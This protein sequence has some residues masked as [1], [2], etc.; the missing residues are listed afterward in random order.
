[1]SDC[2]SIDPLVTPYIDNELPQD[3]HARVDA[4]LRACPPCHSRVAAERAVRDLIRARAPLVCS[5]RAS[6]ALRAAVDF[7][8]RT[9]VG[10]PMGERSSAAIG[11][12]SRLPALA[13]AATLVL[14]V[15]GVFVY[16]GTI[17]SS[18]VLA[19]ELTAD[20]VKCFALNR[21]FGT[22]AEAAAVESAMRAG[23]DWPLHIKAGFAAVG[24]EL[25]GS[26]PCLSGE[27]R[28]A[29]IMCRHNGRP[30][31]IFM[32]PQRARAEEVVEVMGHQARIWSADGRTFV[33]IA[34][35]PRPEVQRMASA[36][37]AALR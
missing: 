32:L 23:F 19:V 10:G 33:M 12:R 34:N 35:E 11:K 31:S 17:H 21:L 3:E 15:G 20:H 13:L 30:V 16:E 2:R 28:V 24:L 22:H 1:M 14:A 27:G 7:A 9:T 26:R 4:H 29:H 6:N 8:C 5:E 36:V 18:R 37:Q 25:I